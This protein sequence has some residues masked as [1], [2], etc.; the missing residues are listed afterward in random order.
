MPQRTDQK[1]KER[2]VITNRLKH[3]S[4]LLIVSLVCATLVGMYVSGPDIIDVRTGIYGCAFV[5]SFGFLL[6]YYIDV[7]KENILGARTSRLIL[8]LIPSI[9]LFILHCGS[10]EIASCSMLILLTLLSGCFNFTVSSLTL[11]LLYVYSVFF[12]AFAVVPSIGTVLFVFAVTL[13]ARSVFTLK[14]SIY[15]ALIVIVFYAIVLIIECDFAAKDIFSVYH[16]I[17]L[18]CGVASLI[19]VRFLVMLLSG[20]FTKGTSALRFSIPEEVVPSTD[21][22]SSESVMLFER[23]N[24]AEVTYDSDMFVKR[25][26][27]EKL[28]ERLSR[29]YKENDE[30]QEKL[31][32]VTDKKSVLSVAD[33][34][35]NDFLY[36]V[37]LKLDNESVYE[38]SLILS[39]L[40]AGAA[41]EISCDSDLAYA[42]GILH[43]A[44]KVLGHDYLEILSSKYYVPD[45]LIRPLY[46]MSVKKVDFP[47]MRETGIVM[48]VNDMINTYDYVLRKMNELKNS[49]DD[50]DL[51]WAGIVRNTIKV[52]NSQNF[53]RYSGF[54]AEE[55][56][57]IKDYLTVAGGDLY[58]IND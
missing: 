2:S 33:V 22:E 47:V 17:V 53:L 55:V 34:C 48:L 11:F 1:D 52:R 45:Y 37:R 57:I 14:N 50:V 44:G 12:S 7:N 32:L 35:S 28:E 29:V 4:F 26:D 18:L 25:E 41:E 38:H 21:D 27:Y 15:S 13:L 31:S 10:V 5:L 39:K 24:E 16:L 19:G 20:G 23:S 58:Q 3:I 56:N 46:H 51:S 42:L 49:G 36:L 8:A 54:S 9:C 6:V 43:D 40:A 30:L